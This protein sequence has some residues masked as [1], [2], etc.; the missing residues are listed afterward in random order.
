MTLEN[1]SQL[2]LYF[3]YQNSFT[4]FSVEILL[5]EETG[6]QFVVERILDQLI[7]VDDQNNGG[8]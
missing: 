6:T 2:Y 4:V 3:T 8:V 5:N 1:D 7:M